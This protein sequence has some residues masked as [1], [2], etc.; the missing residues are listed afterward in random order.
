MP[1]H[2]SAKGTESTSAVRKSPTAVHALAEAHETSD[3]IPV[4]LPGGV[5]IC[6]TDHA[7]PFHASASGRVKPD[8][9]W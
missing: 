4:A 9:F 1:F 7:A 6:W 3:S 2:A 5:G 8:I